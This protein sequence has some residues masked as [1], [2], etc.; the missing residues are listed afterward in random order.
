MSGSCTC[1]C[2]GGIADLTPTALENRPGLSA[3][4]Y[5]VGRHGDFLAS[6]LAALTDPAR[7]RLAALTTRDQDDFSIALLDAWASA[8][9]VLTFYTER[10]A[11]E[12]YLRTARDRISLQELGRLIGYRLRPGV[13]AETYV[14]FALEH[15][16]EAAPAASPDPGAL[17]SVTPG[18]VTLEEGLRIQSI[19]GPGEQP[20]TF[21]TVEEIAARPEWNALRATTTVSSIPDMHDTQAWLQGSALNLE[22]GD[23][24]LLAGPDVVGDRW[25]VRILTA[26]TPLPPS[27][28]GDPAEGRTLVQWDRGLGSIWP[29]KAPADVP[30]PYVLRKRIGVFGHNAPSWNSMSSQFRTDY[31]GST[32][33]PGDWPAFELSAQTG[34]VV[35]LDGSHP[36]VVAGSWIVLAKPSYT[37]LFRVKSSVELSRAQFAIS[38]KVTRLTL[39]GGENYSLFRDAVRTTTV[40]AVSEALTLAEADDTTNVSGDEVSVAGDVSEMVAGRRLLVTG[41]T[42]AGVDEAE[43]AVLA[44][45]SVVDGKATVVLED[46]LA[47]VYERGSV[48]VYGNVAL[49]THGESVDQLLGSGRAD[50]AFQ[51]FTLT[52]GPLTFVQSSDPS[53]VD[54]ALEVR[55]NDVRWDEVPSLYGAGP[56]DRVYAVRDDASGKTYVQFGDG[57][58]GARPPSGSHNVRALYRKG[59]GAAGNVGS[60]TLSVLLDRPLGLKGA[61]NPIAAAGGVDPETEE[62]ARST[63]PVGV[64]TLGRAVSL[65]DY[66][67]Y[68]RGFAGVAKAHAAVLPLRSGRTIVVTVAFDGDPSDVDERLGDLAASLRAYGDPQVQVDVLQHHGQTFRV[69]LRVAVDGA[70]EA[71]AV[72]A[73]VVDELRSAYSF[74]AR[75]F[76]QPVHRSELVAVVHSVAGVVAVDVDQLYSGPTPSLQDRV[77]AQQ[78]HVTASGA[79]APAGL[80]LLDPAPFEPAVMT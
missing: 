49:V 39:E 9:D 66:A 55:V 73:S 6:M 63:I 12:S 23:V 4:A 14:A 15:A 75:D 41:R 19:P 71:D 20:Q 18:E 58:R 33:D 31:R 40:Y 2:C 69:A 1:G 79:A 72:T 26:V 54:S 65:L 57:L 42:T 51:R 24:L 76:V 56:G 32:P 10:L 3:V 74:P 80:L 43:A 35:D 8:C 61:E 36:D 11:Q 47:H 13:A 17:P 48:V 67:D 46:D 22:P 27:P 25:D 16:P 44:E 68:A 21:E 64:R 45:T 38:G 29:S 50:L 34:Q 53:G 59:I 30:E 52:Q 60:R 7:P 37:E 62:T 77:L 78:P 28:G 70:Y 5:R